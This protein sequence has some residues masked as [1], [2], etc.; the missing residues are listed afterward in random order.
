[1][2][3]PSSINISIALFDL[4]LFLEVQDLLDLSHD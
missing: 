3:K 4:L 2:G 1:M